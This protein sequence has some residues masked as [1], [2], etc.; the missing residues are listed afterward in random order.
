MNKHI[1][2]L[3]LA[4]LLVAF[5][6]CS[7][8]DDAEYGSLAVFGTVYT[9]EDY[10]LNGIDSCR[11]EQ[12]L[13]I[14]DSKYIYVG[15]REGAM[16]HIGPS[17]QIIDTHG[18]GMILPGFTE[19]HGHYIMGN[20]INAMHAIMF[21][22]TETPQEFLGKVHDAC[23]WAKENGRKAIYGNGWLLQ[24]YTDE[25]RPKASDLDT[26]CEHLG[27]DIPIYLVDMEGHKGIA[28]SRCMKNAGLLDE[29]GNSLVSG[30]DMI[31][32]GKIELDKNGY[33]TGFM[34]E[35]ASTFVRNK[36]M[37]YSTVITS[38]IAENSVRTAQD[39]LLKN[40]Y[41]NIL[42]GWGNYF[43]NHSFFKALNAMDASGN[44]HSNWAMTYEIESWSDYRSEVDSAYE[45]KKM[46]TTRHVNPSYIKLFMD[47]TVETGTGYVIKPYK[48]GTTGIP[49]WTTDE[50]AG[51]TNLANSKGLAIHSHSFGDAAVKMCID[52]FEKEGSKTIR[53]AMCH[54]RN[55]RPEDFKR[56][57]SNNIACAVGVLWHITIGAAIEEYS[58]LLPDEYLYHGYPMQSYFKAGAVMS[59]STDYPATTGSP[60]NPFGIMQIGV[61]GQWSDPELG[62]YDYTPVFDSEE[63]LSRNQMLQVLTLNGAWQLGIENERGSIKPGKFADFLIVDQ[64]VLECETRSIRDTRILKTFFEGKEVYSNTS[65]N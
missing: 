56:I 2:N 48:D 43:D 29:S 39:M 61:S 40:G 60:Y 28:N 64:N 30:P 57:A 49:N 12:A 3:L 7:E 63:L 54:V 51:I 55:V 27:I 25:D 17:T 31:R 21:S 46:Y 1:G 32:G 65:D 59:Q 20:C 26:I 13:V 19:G 52:A 9:A 53:N 62:V 45:H 24:L 33:P 8:K 5:A 50:V 41:T 4:T 22:A 10:G 58:V 11:M 6:G 14:K 44:L 34:S 18:K 35:Q 42:C 15:S 38:E 23:V 37:D 16:E 36:G 47:G